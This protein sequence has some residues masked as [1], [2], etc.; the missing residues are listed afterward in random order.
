MSYNDNG[1]PEYITFSRIIKAEEL[2]SRW[3]G[4]PENDLAYYARNNTLACYSYSRTLK[5]PAGNFVHYCSPCSGP[6]D[7]G[8]GA[9]YCWEWCG[10]VFN[11]E[12]V[13]E[14]E[15]IHQEFLWQQV[16][17]EECLTCIGDAQPVEQGKNDIE[18]FS[19]ISTDPEWM[20]A[21]EARVV[22]G[23]TPINFVGLLNSGALETDK[24]QE[25]LDY[26]KMD[27]WDVNDVPFFKTNDLDTLRVH[28]ASFA[29]YT[30][31]LYAC[32]KMDSRI[33]KFYK[34][35]DD[36]NKNAEKITRE[37]SSTMQDAFLTAEDLCKRWAISPTQLVNMVRNNNDIAVYWEENESE[38]PF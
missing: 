6:Y 25:R 12:D 9:D 36:S 31:E 5:N 23:M 2:L 15:K 16:P 8:I 35:G 19:S 21:H 1:G 28:K 24:E 20:P 4:C 17:L 34:D 22:I 7:T 10:I 30:E 38:V 18:A 26:A 37:V 13:E 29:E 11:V 27:G 32:R 33:L 3:P 14:F